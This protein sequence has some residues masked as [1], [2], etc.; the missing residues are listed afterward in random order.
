MKRQSL[1]V[2]LALT[3]MILFSGSALAQ[4]GINKGIKGGLNIA[5]LRVDGDDF[6]PSS[7]TGI[8]AGG[9]LEI[10]PIGP[11]AVQAE[12]LYS[13]KG[14]E[15][16]ILGQTAKSTADYIEIP[17]VVKLGLPL[18]PTISYHVH[19]GPAFAFKVSEDTESAFANASDEDAFKSTDFGAV[20]GFGLEFEALISKVTVDARYTLGLT[21]VNNDE[22]DDAIDI[23]NGVVSVLVGI[24]F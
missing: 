17:V 1:L 15:F 24:G 10:D 13:Q 16:E 3:A 23:K 21:N 5:T 11:L 22:A 20:I 18:V 14:A 8:A 2:A 19:A 4:L 7:R 12:V 6:D 9:F